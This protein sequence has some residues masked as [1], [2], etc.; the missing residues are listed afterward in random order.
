MSPHPGVKDQRDVPSRAWALAWCRPLR[1]DPSDHPACC[2]ALAEPPERPDLAIYSQEERLAQGAPATWISPDINYNFTEVRAVVRNLSGRVS[3]VN[4]H[5]A[6]CVSPFG[7]G[8]AQVMV[9]I[10]RLS[11]VPGQELRLVFPLPQALATSPGD[12]D[13]TN[14]NSGWHVRVEH[15]LDR[16][17]I[18]NRGSLVARGVFARDL[19]PAARVS[20]P[21]R[22]DFASARRID[23]GVTPNRL[24][25]TVRPAARQFAPGEQVDAE[26]TFDPALLVSGQEVSVVA[27]AEGGAFV[28]GLTYL[29]M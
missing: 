28:G 29:I 2:I 23:L 25:A 3:A 11:F 26:L 18:N 15:P 5:V 8:T 17:P 4:A 19:A 7:L 21:V 16:Q 24:G 20:F 6:L 12:N 14:G 1:R 22:N 9:G 27:R 10:Q 13:F